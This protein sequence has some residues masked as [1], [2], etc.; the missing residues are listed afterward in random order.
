[1]I[2]PRAVFSGLF[3]YQRSERPTKQF[4]VETPLP[5]VDGPIGH[6]YRPAGALVRE[7]LQSLE[8]V[9][10]ILSPDNPTADRAFAKVKG[11][12]GGDRANDASLVPY[13]ER[14]P[15]VLV[16][17]YQGEFKDTAM[18]R[19]FWYKKTPDG[20][21]ELLKTLP[22]DHPIREIGPAQESAPATLELALK[23]NSQSADEVRKAVA[24]EKERASRPIQQPE[25]TNQQKIENFFV[26]LG[27]VVTTIS[28][29]G[30]AIATHKAEA[31][32]ERVKK[33]IDASGGTKMECPK[34]GGSGKNFYSAY[35]NGTNP[36]PWYSLEHQNFENMREETHESR[37]GRCGGTG[38]VDQ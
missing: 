22:A 32:R 29:A 7:R 2:P 26:R 19:L 18:K 11:L 8:T 25:L 17:G 4:P 20:L 33:I 37:C 12:E 15:A 14:G 24:D 10:R 3:E 36:Y 34:C 27:V 16:C 13:L 1:M 38:V 31:Q 6:G 35:N 5:P 30:E 23:A 28:V 9:V 21:D